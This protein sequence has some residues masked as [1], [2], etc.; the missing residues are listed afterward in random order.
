MLAFILGFYD[1][2]G[3]IDSTIITSA[4]SEFIDDIKNYFNI[5]NKKMIDGYYK[6]NEHT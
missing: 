3:T 6:I 4:S 1:G 2:D 5:K